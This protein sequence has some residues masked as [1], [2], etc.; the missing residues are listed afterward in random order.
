M[1]DIDLQEIESRGEEEI[2]NGPSW[3]QLSSLVLGVEGLHSEGL[4]DKG[5]S[6][7][8]PNKGVKSLLDMIN[9]KY[10]EKRNDLSLRAPIRGKS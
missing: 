1:T 7:S 2:C 10:L 8:A 6:L 5:A 9:L 4:V 3:Q